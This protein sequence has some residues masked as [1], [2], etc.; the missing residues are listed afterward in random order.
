MIFKKPLYTIKIILFSW[1]MIV[2]GFLTDKYRY[3]LTNINNLK[4][5][6]I[7]NDKNCK[8]S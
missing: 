2:H 6:N 7:L 1:D 3:F 4:P 8:E 5:L